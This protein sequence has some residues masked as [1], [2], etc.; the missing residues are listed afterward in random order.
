MRQ[1]IKP[2]LSLFNPLSKH[3]LSKELQKM[4]SILDRHPEFCAWVHKDLT[5]DK[6]DTGCT[7]MSAEQVLRAA[8]IKDIHKLSFEKLAFNLTDSNCTKFFLK[9][10]LEENYSR[11]TLQS[12]I[13]KIKEDTWEKISR[14]IVLDAKEQGFEDCKTVRIDSTVTDSNIAHP[15]DSKLLSDC[16]RVSHREF[17]KLKVIL[18]QPSWRLIPN[19]HVNTAKSLMYK[20]NNSKNNE[21]RLPHYKELLEISSELKK[22]LSKLIVKIEKLSKIKKKAQKVFKQLKDIDF[23]LEKIIY[24]TEK[25]IIK[26]QTVPVEKKIVS[27]FQPHTDIIVKDKRE[28]Q[29]GHKIFL[30][31]GKS[32]MVLNC[33]I[34]EGNPNDADMFLE[35]IESLGKLYS[36]IPKKTSCDGGFSSKENVEKSKESGVKDVCFPKTKKCNMEITEMV[37]SN[38]VYEKLINWR[39]GIEGVISFLKRCF[40]LSKALWSGF[41]G[42]KKAVR[43]GIVSYNLTVL[44]RMEMAADTS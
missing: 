13:S 31:S 15:R 1:I 42:F 6:T 14:A 10:D 40:G 37:K 3:K 38:W 11:S 33:D 21:Q 4:S 25:R 17:K 12:S 36:V 39:A 35:T 28:T 19:K 26:N 18:K 41:D 22:E 9:L 2:Q 30:T 8:V 34:P 23:Y 24:Q 44:A 20:I 7:G 43:C 32:N 27:I 5:E 16:I 29:F